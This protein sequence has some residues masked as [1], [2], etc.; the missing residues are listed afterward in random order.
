M[1]T[2][3]TFCGQSLVYFQPPGSRPH[4][5]VLSQIQVPTGPLDSKQG[6]WSPSSLCTDIPSA[7]TYTVP[8]KD[9][10]PP[11]EYMD[12]GTFLE[13][14]LRRVDTTVETMIEPPPHCLDIT[15]S[16][17]LSGVI[18]PPGSYVFRADKFGGTA[19]RVP[20]DAPNASW[21][22]YRH[23]ASKIADLH[24]TPDTRLHSLFVHN[25]LA[26]LSRLIPARPYEGA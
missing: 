9:F 2:L 24:H 20:D 1:T 26:S 18:F 7:S 4:A 22:T 19:V 12:L 13:L 3:C 25:K 14:P 23:L 10:T 6:H 16:V 15:Q 17:C 8:A 21:S 5:E 11:T